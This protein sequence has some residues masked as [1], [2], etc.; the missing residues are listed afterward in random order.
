MQDNSS[1]IHP[2]HQFSLPLIGKNKVS[3]VKD[4]SELS[5]K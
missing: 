3:I 2:A 1:G 5:E 4:D